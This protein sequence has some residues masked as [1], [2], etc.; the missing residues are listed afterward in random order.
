MWSDSDF[1][2]DFGYLVPSSRVRQTVRNVIAALGIG[3]IAG[4]SAVA[5]LI[6]KSPADSPL[7]VTLDKAHPAARASLVISSVP[8]GIQLPC[9]DGDAKCSSERL[10]E[11][12]G[13]PA[14]A[15][16]T[17]AAVEEPTTHDHSDVSP[18]IARPAIAV[19]QA[20]PPEIQ[21]V[22]ASATATPLPGPGQN[23]KSEMLISKHEVVKR[24]SARHR[25]KLVRRH[26]RIAPR[27]Y[28]LAHRDYSGSWDSSWRQ[29]YREW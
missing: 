6:G 15:V 8:S 13:A 14:D 3:A 21:S 16:G 9:E 20:V 29:S 28:E 27:R 24:A 11:T 2:P 18:G 7:S 1:H 25:S 22:P 10:A 5:A 12:K 17:F 4:A 23:T 19:P 26:E